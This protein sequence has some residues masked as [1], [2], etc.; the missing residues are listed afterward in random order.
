MRVIVCSVY[1]KSV[2]AGTPPHIVLDLTWS[3]LSSE[4]MKA[5]TRNLGLPTIS[6]SYGGVGDLK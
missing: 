6:G 2:D 1:D 3:G 5:L 4:V